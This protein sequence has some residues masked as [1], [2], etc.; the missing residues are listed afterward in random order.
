ML[1]HGDDEHIAMVSTECLKVT[2]RLCSSEGSERQ[3]FARNGDI[4]MHAFDELEKD[5]A[6]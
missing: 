5:V 4:G 2:R 1:A 6:V 3:G